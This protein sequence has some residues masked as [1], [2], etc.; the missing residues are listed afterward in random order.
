MDWAHYTLADGSGVSRYNL[1]TASLLT[2]LL[3]YMFRNFAVMPE[4]LAALPVGGVD[5]TLTR[6]MR[7]MT[8]EGVLRAKTGTLRGANSTCWLYRNCGWGNG[9]VLDYNE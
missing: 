1:V 4:Y 7:G 9:G 2:D 6:R 8:A 3:V 5:G